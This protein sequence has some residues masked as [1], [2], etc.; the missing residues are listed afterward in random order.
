MSKRLDHSCLLWEINDHGDDPSTYYH[1]MM[2]EVFAIW[3]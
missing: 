2:D 3:Q 1:A